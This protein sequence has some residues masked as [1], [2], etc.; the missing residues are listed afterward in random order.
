MQNFNIHTHTKRCGHAIG[1][2]EEYVIAAIEAGIKT[3]G[4]S[5]HCP[6][7]ENSIQGDRME[8]IEL[9]SYINSITYLKNKYANEINIKIGFECEFYPEKTEY[10]EYLLSRVEYLILGQ[11]YPVI[12]GIDYCL[13]S[14]DELVLNYARQ[15]CEGIES[16]YF[17]YVAHPDY[18]MLPRTNWS[19][20]CTRAVEMICKAASYND[21]PLEINL[22]G[23]SYGKQKFNDFYTYF[24]PH[25]ETVKLLDKYQNKL[26][27]GLDCHDPKKFSNMQSLMDE[28]SNEYINYNLKFVEN[29]SDLK[30]F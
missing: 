25:L 7:E 15:V 2:D 26:V 19:D 20:A 6:F 5:D 1:E 14:T 3:L 28:F 18:F 22:K 12:N 24:Y 9:D 17:T 4:F 21:L 29:I 11:H 10:Y 27:F 8:M 30:N 16:G 23:L 13:L